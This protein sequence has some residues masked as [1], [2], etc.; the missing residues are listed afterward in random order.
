MSDLELISLLRQTIT[1]ARVLSMNQLIEQLEQDIKEAEGRV[2]KAS[3]ECR[4]AVLMASRE[5]A[6]PF[7]RYGDYDRIGPF[8]V[9]YYGR[10][11]RLELGSEFY[12]E[13][14]EIDGTKIFQTIREAKQ[15]LELQTFDRAKF[16]RLLKHAYRLAKDEGHAR[17][18][19]VSVFKLYAYV[20]ILR[21]ILL[22]DFLKNPDL[23][24]I[25]GYTKAQFVFDLARFG[26]KDWVFGEE[27]LR[28]RTPNMATVESGKVMSLPSLD[29]IDGYGPQLSVVRIDKRV[30]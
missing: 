20:F 13:F 28:T 6:I 4:E 1:T 3:E 9:T 10:K 18:G 25:E 26:Q 2:N 23:R 30:I 11:V 12:K 24:K 29:K 14:E 17:D 22:A 5:A 15:S 19:W 8:K 21:P 27:I 7:K 16:F